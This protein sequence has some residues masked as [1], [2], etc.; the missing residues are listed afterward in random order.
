[1]P[2]TTIP[3]EKRNS[4]E[5]RKTMDMETGVGVSPT[6]RTLEHVL[7]MT[8]SLLGP[9]QL[10]TEVMTPQR[11]GGE[12]TDLGIVQLLRNIRLEK[13]KARIVTPRRWVHELRTWR[14]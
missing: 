5:S 10:M 11:R 8:V 7:S 1:M 14:A 6:N 13:Q 3:E 2:K 4:H 9:Y 12:Q